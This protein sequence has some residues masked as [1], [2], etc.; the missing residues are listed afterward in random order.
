MERTI[1]HYDMDSFY[2][3]VEMRDNKKYIGKPIVVAGGVVTTANYEAR[4]F[5]IHSAMSTIEAKRLCPRVIVVPVNKTKYS[6]ESKIIQNLA[7][8][9]TD[10][11]EF[12]AL[13]EGYIDI[14][15]IISK[16]SSKKSFASL[17]RKRIFEKTGLTCSVGIGINKL[18]AKIASDINKPGGQYIFN[19][20][21][22]FIEFIRHKNIRKLP[23]VGVKFEKILTKN[24]IKKVD[25]IFPF[26]LKELT[27]KFGTSRGELLYTFSRGIDFREVDFKRATHSIGNEITFRIPLDSEVEINRE[28]DDLFIWAHKRLLKNKFLTKTISLKIRYSNRDTITRAKTRAIPTDNIDILKSMLD[29]LSLAVDISR[30]I[31]LLGVSFSSLINKSKRQLTLNN[32]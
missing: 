13:D 27:A 26:S 7:L 24:N 14:T 11:V 12:I 15:N 20:Q 31:R 18:T 1:L 32:F 17:F 29:E 30:D 22:E 19:N 10:K 25:D 16:Y 4:K 21:E 9:I 23:G 28:I 6:E 3:S 8:K 5:G 2:A